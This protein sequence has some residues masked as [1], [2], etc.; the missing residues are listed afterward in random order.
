MFVIQTSF[1]T[2]D[3]ETQIV[4]EKKFINSFL[5]SLHE[6]SMSRVFVREFRDFFSF[7]TSLF[8]YLKREEPQT[9]FGLEQKAWGMQC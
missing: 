3:R 6:K 8:Y 7:T 9:Q 5:Y 1:S 4:T 2:T